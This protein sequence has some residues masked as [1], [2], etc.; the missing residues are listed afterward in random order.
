MSKAESRPVTS[1]KD[2]AKRK[3]EGSAQVAKRQA[4]LRAKRKAEGRKHLEL[5]P[6]PEHRQAIKDFAA[7]LEAG[8]WPN[9]AG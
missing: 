4:D 7:Q 5:W 3:P 1:P 8:A 2:G 6:L 9:G